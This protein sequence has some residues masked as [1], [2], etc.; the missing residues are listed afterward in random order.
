MSLQ[1]ISNGN[2]GNDGGDG[3]GANGTQHVLLNMCMYVVWYQGASDPSVN[4]KP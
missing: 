1:V 3:G 2:I 4:S